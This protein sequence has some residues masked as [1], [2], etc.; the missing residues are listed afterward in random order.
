M[1]G[2]R[3]EN[4]GP[5]PQRAP[6]VLAERPWPGKKSDPGP[7]GTGSTDTGNHGPRIL[8]CIDGFN[9][10]GA[11]RQLSMLAVLLARRGYRVEAVTYRPTRFFDAAVE[12]AGVPIHRLPPSGRLRRALAFR[13][14][15]R[16]RGPDV[17]IA[18]LDG[19]G[20]YS[21]LAGLPRRRFGLIVSEFSVPESGVR[22]GRRLRLAAHRLADAV[23]TET[24][25]VR[26]RLIGAVPWLAGRIVVIPNGVDLNEFRPPDT[27]DAFGG[28]AAGATRVLVLAGYRREKNPFG[29]LAAAEHLRRIAPDARVEFNWYGATGAVDGQDAIFRALRNEVRQRGLE[30]VFRLHDA[31]RDVAPLYREASL[32]CLPS[33][34][35]GCSNV[36]CEAAASGVPLV[37]SDVCDNPRFVLDGVTGFL[38][39]PHAPKTFADAI[40][41]VHRLPAA[42]RR[43]M[44]RR[45]R[46]HAE[47]LFDPDRFAN[48]FQA[49]I[50]RVAPG[51]RSALPGF[52]SPPTPPGGEL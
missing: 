19:P 44:A 45:A 1:K 17:V 24:D 14:L 16:R 37:V 12:A 49:L 15:L 25:Y 13:R 47:A 52:P 50:E 5:K 30:D 28:N 10:G 38:A 11:Q 18:F 39:D 48:S 27:L 21:E 35:E 26:G 20:L 32:V 43:E 6:S 3:G 29:M 42:A 41:R 8:C 22:G 31:V 34:F 46:A 23:V 40:L 9:Q 7:G 2:Q 51:R 36:I 33:F 4:G